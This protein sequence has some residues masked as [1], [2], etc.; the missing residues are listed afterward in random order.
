MLR[1]ALA[2][3]LSSSLLVVPAPASA[4]SYEVLFREFDARDLTLDDKRFLQTALAFAGTYRGLLDGAWGSRSQ[5]AFEQYSEKEFGT[6][7]ED[8]HM[9]LLAYD[10]FNLLER[11]GWNIQYLPALGMSVMVPAKTLI[12]DAPSDDFINYRHSRSSLSI[13]VGT[14]TTRAAQNVHKYTLGKRNLGVAPYT[15]RRDN[16]AVTSVSLPDGSTIYTRSNYISDAWSTIILSASRSDANIL[17]AVSASISVGHASRLNITSGGKLDRIIAKAIALSKERTQEPPKTSQAVSA[18]PSSTKVHPEKSGSAGS[19]FRVSAEGHVMTNAHVIA[20]CKEISVD[21]RAATLV[22]KSESFDLAILKTAP[23]PNGAVAKFA[24]QPARLN[25]DVTAI[26]YP[27]AGA[28]SGLNVTRGSVSSM[29]GLANDTI[30]MQITAPVQ[31]GNSGGPLVASDGSVVGVVVSKLDVVKFAS[32]VGDMPQNVNFA[33]RGE[34]A[35][36]FL[37]QNGIEPQRRDGAQPLSPED[38]AEEAKS[39]TTFIECQ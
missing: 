36:L 17:N 18:P 30:T 9:A 28:L 11:D 34:L 3:T 14:L 2:I 29:K 22:D 4:Q 6:R 19:G 24:S 13:S 21:G 26:G 10:F 32:I 27:Y 35:Q 12:T 25:S 38:L 23:S 33:V 31:S 8:W 15:V 39:Y 7:S 1:F 5:R 20:S 37:S 16:F